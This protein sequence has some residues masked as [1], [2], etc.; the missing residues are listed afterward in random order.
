MWLGNFNEVSILVCYIKTK[1]CISKSRICT[2][3]Q[4]VIQEILNVHSKESILD[5]VRS[6]EQ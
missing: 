3:N 5:S 1:T 4:S 6:K 2:N